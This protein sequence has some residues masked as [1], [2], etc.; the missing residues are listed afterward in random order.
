MLD[1]RSLQ[2]LTAVVLRESGVFL[3]SLNNINL[4]FV[5]G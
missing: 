5:F 1:T 4:I 3:E 2:I